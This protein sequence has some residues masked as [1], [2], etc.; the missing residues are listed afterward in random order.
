MKYNGENYKKIITNESGT[1]YYVSKTGKVISKKVHIHELKV[2]VTDKGYMYVKFTLGKKS[3]AKFIHRLVAQAYIPNPEKKPE[4]NHLDGNKSNNN[5]S[6][7]EWVTSKENKKHARE[8][9][10]SRFVSG[11]DSGSTSL[12]NKQIEKSCKMMEKNKLPLK[13]IAKKLNMPVD[14]LYSIRTKGMWKNISKKYNFPK[15]PI[16]NEVYKEHLLIKICKELEK[17]KLSN[18]EISKKYNVGI[19]TVNDIK[20]RRRHKD[21]SKNY[22]F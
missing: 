22:S 19:S 13:E 1:T 8:N 11:E 15:V 20:H 6:N 14:T 5:V 12:T 9:D 10:L 3:R 17:G 16:S 21:I 2:F 7:L 4:V 18:K